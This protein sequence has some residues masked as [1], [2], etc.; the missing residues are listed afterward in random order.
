M[1]LDKIEGMAM[2]I[3]LGILLIFISLY[4]SF[5]KAQIQKVIKPTKG[6]QLGAGSLSGIMGG[7]FGIVGLLLGVPVFA[8]LHTL[9]KE[10]SERKLIKKGLPK[11]TAEWMSASQKANI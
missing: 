2:K 4:F 9:I 11:S 6:W 7:L 3:V 1:L 5:F 10:H 8:V